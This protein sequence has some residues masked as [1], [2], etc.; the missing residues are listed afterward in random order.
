MPCGPY[1]FAQFKADTGLLTDVNYT[2]WINDIVPADW[3]GTAVGTYTNQF[4]IW[5]DNLVTTFVKN[6]TQWALAINPNLQFGCTPHSIWLNAP[7]Y[8]SYGQG[9]DVAAWIEDGSVQFVMPMLY[10]SSNDTATFNAWLAELP[11]DIQGWQQYTLGGSHGIVPIIGCITDG[12]EAW[13]F[14]LTIAQVNDTVNTLLANSADGWIMNAYGGAGAGTYYGNPNGDPNTTQY[15]DAMGLPNP[16]TFA[17]TS[18]NTTALSSTSEQISWT[19]SSAANS[20]IEYNSSQLFVWSQLTSYN[21]TSLGFPYWEDN[22]IPSFINTDATLVTY[23]VM[24]LT[25]LTPGTKYYFRV[26]SADLSGT[27]TTPVMRFST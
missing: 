15:F 16:Q 19:T 13:G 10:P 25:G 9:Q 2:T 11:A 5:R 26:Q 21:M 7:D 24:T 3:G 6:I 17:I 22:H 14:N 12:G 27:A 8:W 18:I 1:D 4:L 23:H 20:T